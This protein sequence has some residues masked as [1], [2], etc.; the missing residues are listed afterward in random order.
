M[1]HSSLVCQGCSGTL[2]A[3][4]TAHTHFAHLLS[5]EVDH[6]HTPACCPLRPFLPLTGEADH[7]HELAHA[8]R[9]LTTPT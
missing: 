1:I 8:D 7:I 4:S 5:W 9:V 6:D 3:V 2:Y